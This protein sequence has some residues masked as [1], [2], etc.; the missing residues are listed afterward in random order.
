MLQDM[1][2][3]SVTALDPTESTFVD[4]LD[5]YNTRSLVVAGGSVHDIYEDY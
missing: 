1:D 4:R 5:K 2:N 3:L